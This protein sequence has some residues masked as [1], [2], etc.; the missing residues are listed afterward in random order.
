MAIFQRLKTLIKS[1]VN[2]WINKSEDAE[3][4]LNQMLLDMQQQLIQAKQQV[5]VAIADE[6]K[7]RK[8][9]E[10]ESNLSKSWEEK[11]MLAVNAGNDSLAKQALERKNEHSNTAKGFEQ[12]WIGQQ[13]SVEQ[14]KNALKGL[15]SKI[16]DAKRKKNLLVARAKRA[17]AQK[18]ISET[19]SGLSQNS[20]VDTINRMEEKIDKMEAEAS[21][22]SELANE[23]AV[24]D[25]EQQFK[26]LE[27]TETDSAL[28]D[29]KKKMGVSKKASVSSSHEDAKV[30]QQIQHQI[31]EE[32]SAKK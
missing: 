31:E 22:T 13:K 20:A 17:E 24:D 18:T 4:M 14:L 9:F 15:Q 12:Q 3:K 28:D 21:A 10:T 1:N 11:A 32:V 27:T 8:Q 23:I 16:E 2:H 26:Q 7:L 30:L 6:K 25:L 19:M 29:L 5:A